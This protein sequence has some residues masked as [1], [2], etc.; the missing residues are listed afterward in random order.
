MSANFFFSED[1]LRAALCNMGV[2]SRA[3]TDVMDK[4]RNRHYQ[5]RDYTLF[6]MCASVSYQL[7]GVYYMIYGNLICSWLAP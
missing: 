1:N 3:M 6:V 5:V 2:S 7:H 4:V